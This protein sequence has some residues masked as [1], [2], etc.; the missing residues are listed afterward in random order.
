[1]NIFMV[2]VWEWILCLLYD[3]LYQNYLRF[4]FGFYVW[5]SKSAIWAY[6]SIYKNI[7]ILISVIIWS[8][9]HINMHVMLSHCSDTVF[10]CLANPL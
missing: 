6:E 7:V 10:P 1:M 3:L 8:V 9:M 4:H 5:F 2:Y